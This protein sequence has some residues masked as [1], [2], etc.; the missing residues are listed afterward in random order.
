MI[1]AVLATAIIAALWAVSGRRSD[2]RSPSTVGRWA[3]RTGLPPALA[4]G[5]RLAVEPGRGR[6]AVPV[7]SAL[8]GAVVGVLGVVG[9]F[10]FRDG[11]TDAAA[12]PQRSGVVWDYVL[13]SGDGAVTSKQLADMARDKDVQGVLHAVWFR[14]VSIKGVATPTFGTETLRGNVAPVVLTGR[15]PREREPRSRSDP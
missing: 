1:A 10:T 15:A 13:G 2:T 9:C 7:R 5:S 12:S 6:R 11:L 14:A 4:I 3:A 8:I